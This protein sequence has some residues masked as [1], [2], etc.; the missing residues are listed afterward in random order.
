MK[1]V[2]LLLLTGLASV[3]TLFATI[4]SASA[5]AWFHYQPEV[6]KCLRK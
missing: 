4:S 3:L 6:P 1:K 2:K 5:C